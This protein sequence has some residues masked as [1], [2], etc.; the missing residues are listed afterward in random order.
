MLQPDML[1]S[2]RACC[3]WTC[4]RLFEHVA[5]GHV[6]ACS[7][8]LQLDSG[9][10]AACSSMLQLD[11]LPFIRACCSRTCCRLFEHVATWFEHFVARITYLAASSELGTTRP[12]AAQARERQI[13]IV[14]VPIFIKQFCSAVAASDKKQRLWKSSVV[15]DSAWNFLALSAT[16]F[17]IFHRCRRQRLNFLAIS[18]TALKSTNWQFWIFW[19]IS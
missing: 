1:P 14:I 2:F 13:C 16:A 12:G 7:S 11:M 4:C 3:S 8:M 5:A 9:H 17:K 19:P 15:G 6:A 10:V 18:A